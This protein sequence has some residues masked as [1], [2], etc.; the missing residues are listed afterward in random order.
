[1]TGGGYAGWP[2]AGS[3]AVRIPENMSA[4]GAAV[5]LWGSEADISKRHMNPSAS[6]MNARVVMVPTSPE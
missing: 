4:K 5:Q 6:F 3:D 1:M 2:M